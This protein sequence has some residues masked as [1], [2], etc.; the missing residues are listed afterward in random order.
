MPVKFEL[1]SYSLPASEKD[2]AEL[3]LNNG[4]PESMIVS[5]KDIEH[6]VQLVRIELSERDKND[7]LTDLNRILAYF[8]KLQEVDTREVPPLSHPLQM[9]NGLREDEVRDSLPV[10]SAL[11]NAPAKKGSYFSVP[12]V[13]K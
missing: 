6:L 12:K 9:V 2:V 5:K 3:I 1:N 7:L 8:E 4:C 11:R 10:E 13:I